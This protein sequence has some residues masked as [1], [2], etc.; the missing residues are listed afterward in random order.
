MPSVNWLTPVKVRHTLIGGSEKIIVYDDLEPSE[1]VRMFS[2]PDITNLS[3]TRKLYMRCWSVIA[4]ETCGRT[5][6]E[7][8]EALLTGAL[9]FIDCINNGTQAK[10][11]GQAGLRL[12]QIVAAAERSLRTREN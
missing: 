11:D 4:R 5:R 2:E 3:E 8:T 1:K 12:I 6:L 7:A 10:T 9:H